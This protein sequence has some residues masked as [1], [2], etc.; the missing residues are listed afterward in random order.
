MVEPR[1]PCTGVQRGAFDP[2]HNGHLEIARRATMFDVAEDGD[3]AAVA[4]LVGAAE[5][6]EPEPNG[7][8]PI[9]LSGDNPDEPE[10]N[11]P[12]LSELGRDDPNEPESRGGSGLGP[13]GRAAGEPDHG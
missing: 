5:P 6:N 2:I 9:E 3:V 7:L 4:H 13:P 8:G 10:A 11:G 12:G 1:G